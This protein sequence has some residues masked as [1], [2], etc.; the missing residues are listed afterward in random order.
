MRWPL[1]RALV[2]A[3]TLCRG[4]TAFADGPAAPGSN[5]PA[6]N[7]AAT[8]ACVTIGDASGPAPSSGD[9]DRIELPAV[10]IRVAPP[11]RAEASI[12]PPVDARA[13]SNATDATSRR[14]GL[15]VDPATGLMIPRFARAITNAARTSHRQRTVVDRLHLDPSTGLMVPD[16]GDEPSPAPEVIRATNRT[17]RADTHPVASGELEIDPATGLMIPR[18]LRTPTPF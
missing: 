15:V 12:A 7:G 8:D 14:D 13:S 5:T 6:V 18:G 11:A 16:F 3:A 1:A 2:I 4:A 10:E 9:A 17:R